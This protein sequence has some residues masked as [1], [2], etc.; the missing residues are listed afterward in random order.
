MSTG[1]DSRVMSWPGT[2]RPVGIFL[3]MRVLFGVDILKAV[4]GLVCVGMGFV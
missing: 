3:K 4:L 2:G 1:R